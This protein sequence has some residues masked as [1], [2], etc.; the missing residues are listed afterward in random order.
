MSRVAGRRDCDATL[1]AL[2][3]DG[4]GAPAC[5]HLNGKLER[6]TIWAT[7]D[8]IDAVLERQ[9]G[10]V[11]KPGAPGLLAAWDFSQAISTQ[12]AADVGPRAAY[13]RLVNLPARAMT[14]AAWNGGVQ[15]WTRAPQQYGAIH[16][17]DDDQGD[18]GWQESA[19]LDIPVDWPS[20]LYSA[21]VSNEAAEDFIPFFVR[22]ASPHSDVAF[23]A[24]T[25]TY[26]VYGC[27]RPPRTRREIA[28]R[29]AA[30]GRCRRR[31]T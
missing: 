18:L 3:P 29:A 25:Y 11:P 9:L 7:S 16:F 1:A 12:T 21:H 4:S 31:P 30:W 8:A 10:T 27:L 24:P 20:G 2:P 14:G 23:L 6:P 22:P 17:H 5:A 19:S 26:Q 28:E 15:D 13:A